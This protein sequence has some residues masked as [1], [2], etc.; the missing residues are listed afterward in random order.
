MLLES[1]KFRA[2]PDWNGL[3]QS[4]GGG[5]RTHTGVSAQRIFFKGIVPNRC[6]SELTLFSSGQMTRHEDFR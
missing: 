1:R 6:S 3:I 5:S 2:F 4:T